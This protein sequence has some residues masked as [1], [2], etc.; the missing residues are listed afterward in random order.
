MT[1]RQ[2]AGISLQDVNGT[3]TS[4]FS[5]AFT[6][7]DQNIRLR[8][9]ECENLKYSLL[10]NSGAM[11]SNR[12]SWFYNLKG[13]S[14][15]VET[16]CSSSLVACHLAA[17]SLDNRESSMAIV[18]GCNFIHSPETTIQLGNLGVLSQDSKCYS[19]DDKANG[20]ARGDGAAVVVLKR[21]SDAVR[22]GDTIRGV[23][24]NIGCNQDGKSPGV[25][26]PTA[27]AQAALI[28]RLYAE[29][30]LDPGLTRYFE[31]HATG[32][33]VGDP[34][35][36][37]AIAGAFA[38]HLSPE[39]PMYVGSVK[40]NVGHLEGA[41][42]LAGLL[43]GIYI[44]E[45][46]TIPAHL[47]FD[48]W[49]AQVDMDTDLF[50][51]PTSAV[52][53]P[54]DVDA[55]RRVSVNSFGI[56]GTNAHVILDDARSYLETHGLGG[57]H[58][59]QCDFRLRREGSVSS[60]NQSLSSWEDVATPAQPRLF[61]LSAFDENGVGRLAESYLRHLEAESNGPAS[62]SGRFLDDM[63][64][65]LAAKRTKFVWRTSVVADSSESLVQALSS[66]EKPVRSTMNRRLGLVFTGQGAQWPGMGR[67]LHRYKV[68]CESVEAA[69]RYLRTLGCSWSVSGMTM[70][71]LSMA[72]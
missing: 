41:A 34:I 14:L 70:H 44:L 63:A 8:D 42:G 45:S 48:K 17:Q 38:R 13:Q 1:W 39:K 51:V 57:H 60:Q 32:T 64:Y 26:V 43:K 5:G 58:A 29:A 56:G 52:S 6:Y 46:G 18:T 33:A 4:V 59:T 21:V 36:L 22:D 30:A 49:T 12:I 19:L 68:F 25:T 37:A 24:R 50:K 3:D 53:W 54:G 55:V 28:N 15:T 72:I 40:T 69:S 65:T 20:Y 11:L 9:L 2:K 10:G 62:A 23:I 16:A 35:E 27:E 66:T 71:S 61:V 7:E 67:E 47:W 31:A